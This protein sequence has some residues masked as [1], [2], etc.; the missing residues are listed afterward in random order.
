MWL[1]RQGSRSCHVY[2]QYGRVTGPTLEVDIVVLVYG[3]DIVV[4]L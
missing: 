1:R 2:V 4:S 3:T